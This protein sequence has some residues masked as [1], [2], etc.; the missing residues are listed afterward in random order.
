[1]TSEAS[2]EEIVTQSRWA[3]TVGKVCDQFGGE[4][5]TGPFGS[6]LH[7]SDYSEEGTPVVMPQ[8]MHDGKIICERIARVGPKHVSQLKRHTL[9]AGDVVYSRRGDVTRFAVVTKAEAGWL[10]GTGSI[11]IRLNCPEIE[12]GYVR[13][14][15]QQEAVGKWLKHHAKGVTMP[16]LNTDV[17]RALPFVYPPLAEQR[18]IAEVL[19]RA[20]ALRAN[21]RA[22]LVQL[23]SLAQ[24]LFLGLFG[25]TRKERTRWPTVP[26]EEIVRQTKLGLVRGSQEFGPEFP[27]PYVRMN[28]ITRNGELELGGVQRTHATEAEIE[29]YRLEPGDFLFNTRN[30]EELVGKTALFRGNGLHLF[31][32]NLMRIRFAAQ[33]DPEFVAAAFK[34]AFVQYELSL[35]KSGT[36]NVFAIYYKDLRSLPLPL[37]PIE[38]QHEFARR[39]GAVEKL[40]T[41]QRVSLAEMDAL[42]ASLQHRAFRGEL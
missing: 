29:A 24:S 38:L 3:T 34:T 17:I 12:V 7:A 25:D 6:Q 27:F 40:K 14:Y 37:P 21:R 22:A 5:Q 1:V 41:A 26:L 33:A 31:N 4:V 30:S 23:D 36:T 11:R 19:D 39:V 35:R 15:L 13:R 32:N 10:C 9:V 18:R 2:I 20:E 16:N 28:A 42:F 8:D